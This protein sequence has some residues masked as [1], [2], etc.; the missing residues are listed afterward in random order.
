[1]S[2]PA[3][4]T[5]ANAPQVPA[6]TP[7]LCMWSPSSWA[8]WKQCPQKWKIRAD[9][10]NNPH[11]KPDRRIAVI[12]IPGLVIDS[13]FEMWLHRG[14]YQDR[15]WLDQNY[16]MVWRMVTAKRKPKWNRPETEEATLLKETAKSVGILYDLLHQHRLLNKEMHIQNDFHEVIA[17]GISIAGAIDLWT[18]R[19][20][21]TLVLVDF[22]NARADKH[23]SIDQLHIYSLAIERSVGA[24]PDE[25]GYVC[26]SPEAPGYQRRELRQCDRQ[27]LMARLERASQDRREGRCSAKYNSFYCPRYC[28][29]RFGC[30]EFM[31]RCRG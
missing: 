12:A 30:P 26:F 21:G 1:M 19:D 23:R 14:D 3:N 7:E 25:V 29:V 20:D 17:P 15:E 31:K 27:K 13:L 6:T 22:K 9:K 5:T 10:W 8:S 24:E 11:A 16:D 28:E 4:I 18:F 2:T